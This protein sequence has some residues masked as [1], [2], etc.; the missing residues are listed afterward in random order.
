MSTAAYV[1]LLAFSAVSFPFSRSYAD[2][3]ASGTASKSGSVEQ[4]VSSLLTPFFGTLMQY[5]FDAN[6]TWASPRPPTNQTRFVATAGS[7][8][9]RRASRDE[10]FVK[11]MLH[12]VE[13]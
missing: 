5:G 6:R 10:T 1:V 3:R 13:E 11:A 7:R 4:Y 12:G 2:A 8:C 9:R